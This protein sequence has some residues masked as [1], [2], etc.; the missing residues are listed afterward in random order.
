MWKCPNCENEVTSLDYTVNTT[1]SEYGRAI[2]SNKKQEDIDAIVEDHD[3]SDNGDTEW[4]GSPN[5]RCPECDS[6]LDPT[7]L[8]WEEENEETNPTQNQRTPEI[9]EKPRGKI[10]NEWNKH[11]D[12]GNQKKDNMLEEGNFC[13]KCKYF[14]PKEY[15]TN[16][17]YDTT[18]TEEATCPNCNHTFDTKTNRIMIKKKE[19]RGLRVLKVAIITKKKKKNVKRL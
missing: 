6:D 2:L 17:T 7:D 5:Y 16:R 10:E 1:G 12:K 11:F 15:T 8:I 19:E 9:E 18:E 13:P 14:F 3:Y 4:D